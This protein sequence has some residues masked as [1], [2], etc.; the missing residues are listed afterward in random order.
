MQTEP[1]KKATVKATVMFPVDRRVLMA[2]LLG[3]LPV[4]DHPGRWTLWVGEELCRTPCMFD[5]S[6]LNG[7]TE[8]RAAVLLA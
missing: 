3:S 6:S 1:K 5:P 7:N 8:C 4:L 2:E